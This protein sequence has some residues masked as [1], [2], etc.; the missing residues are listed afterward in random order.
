MIV[1]VSAYK[2]I[3]L[4]DLLTLQ[5]S[6]KKLGQQCQVKGTILLSTE[7]INIALSGSQEAIT[8]FKSL[9]GEDPR[10]ADIFYKDS[11][12]A[13]PGFSKLVVRVRKAIINMGV[14]GIEPC[15]YDNTHL[16]PEE[17]KQW[18]D[19]KRDVL[20]LD[21]RNNYEVALGTYENALAFDIETFKE[22]PQAIENL[23]EEYKEKP[24]VMFCTGG[25][26]CEKAA[27]YMLEKGFKKVYQLDGG[28]I[29]YF[30][31]CGGSHFQGEC[32]VFDDRISIDTNLQVTG[33]VL[34]KNCGYAVTKIE[35][36]SP[37]FILDQQ[38][39]H[40]AEQINTQHAQ[41]VNSCQNNI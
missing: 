40:C 15:H 5:V 25:V 17:F 11:L 19:E 34:C 8:H 12:S 3:K 30:E 4:D 31:K 23:S 16:S 24:I 27:P 7:G 28:I 2:F 20:V 37:H 1:N 39:P 38:C 18:L 41:A 22:F 13:E 32:F 36:Q 14:E 35:Q 10:F 29:N 33:A 26:R 9:L 6:I 21:T